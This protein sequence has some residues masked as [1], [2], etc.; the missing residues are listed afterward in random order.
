MREKEGVDGRAVVLF[1]LVDGTGMEIAISGCRL[2]G[3]WV[4]GNV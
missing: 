2:R 3:M 4:K 1:V